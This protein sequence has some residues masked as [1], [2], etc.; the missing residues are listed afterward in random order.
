M[1]SR[2]TWCRLIFHGPPCISLVDLMYS[3]TQWPTSTSCNKW[4]QLQNL[5]VSLMHLCD[6]WY[7]KIFNI[8]ILLVGRQVTVTTDG[9]R[10]LWMSSVLPNWKSAGVKTKKQTNKSKHLALHKDE[11]MLFIAI[12]SP[13]LI[14]SFSTP[15]GTRTVSLGWSSWPDTTDWQMYPVVPSVSDWSYTLR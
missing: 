9:L 10:P 8:Y 15:I 5:N 6:K 1:T 14:I 3:F 11:T 13:G 7:Y 2:N 12:P 4:L